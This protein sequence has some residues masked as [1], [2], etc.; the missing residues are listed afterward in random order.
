MPEWQRIQCFGSRGLSDILGHAVYVGFPA[1][2]GLNLPPVS[3]EGFLMGDV[4][5]EVRD[6]RTLVVGMQR[7]MGRGRRDDRN[8]PDLGGAFIRGAIVAAAHGIKRHD[9][10]EQ[11]KQRAATN[12]AMLSVP[13]WAAELATSAVGSF[14]LGLASN[15]RAFPTIASRAH[16]F[17]I[18]AN[19]RPLTLDASAVAVFVAEGDAI[20]TCE[21]RFL[22]STLKPYSVKSLTEFTEE[23]LERSDIEMLMK[24][25][26]GDAIGSALEQQFFSA[27]AGTTAAPPGI[28]NGVTATAA[29]ASF[30]EDARALVDVIGDPADVVFVVAPGRLISLS[31]EMDLG[32]F[33]A[34]VLASSGVA[35]DQLVAVDCDDLAVGLGG[36]SHK[37]G[38][39]STIHEA[40]PA[41]PISTPGTPAT[42]ASPMRSLWQTD[43]ISLKSVL[44]V[45]W[46]RAASGAAF[47]DNVAW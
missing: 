32:A 3:S 40:N 42:V 6:L 37:V 9:L 45:S 23:M 7:A 25:L 18:S 10:A 20:G 47:I 46:G 36:V 22:A 17:E 30:A 44:S 43:V 19:F 16:G 27:T 24:Q 2:E 11:W 1:P 33:A 38:I 26:L 34:P 5:Q 21:A 41:L 15:V 39:E 4:Q 12:P 13:T 28:L 31:A 14:I 29:G 35:A 8:E